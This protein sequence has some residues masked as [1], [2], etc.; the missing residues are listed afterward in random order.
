MLKQASVS[1]NSDKLFDTY[2]VRQ[3]AVVSWHNWLAAMKM[4]QAPFLRLVGR[5]RNGANESHC[6]A[7]YNEMPISF[8][9]IN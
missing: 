9:Q 2:L 5:Q 7:L 8:E 4:A 6:H 3:H 1:N